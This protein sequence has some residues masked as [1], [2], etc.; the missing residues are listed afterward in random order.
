MA[1]IFDEDTSD[2]DVINIAE[3]EEDDGDDDKEE[4]TFVVRDF[5]GFAC[6]IQNRSSKQVGTQEVEKRRFKEFFGTSLEVVGI[7]WE[8]LY[9]RDFLPDKSQLK[10][11]LWSCYF[12]KDYPKQEAGCLAVGGISGAI[13]PKTM[14]HW[15]W[16]FIKRI[17]ELVDN[18]VRT[19][20]Y[21]LQFT[22]ISFDY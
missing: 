18:V 17:R 2:N 5:I 8:M 20:H 6:D 11:L 12:L 22:I 3:E 21:I 4:E 16:D 7:L 13:S 14:K 15:V 10:H 19:S 9:E 1:T